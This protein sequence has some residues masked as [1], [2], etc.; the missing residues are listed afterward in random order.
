MDM[1][2]EAPDAAFD[3]AS[4]EADQLAA[5]RADVLA[6]LARPQ[7]AVP[8]RWLY[9][10][11]GSEL[12]EEITRQPEYYL[13][14]TE[15]AILDENAAE[16]AA[17][18]GGDAV[19]LEY[20]AGAGVKTEILLKALA[21]PATYVPIDISGE[22]VA[23]SADRIDRRFP[24]IDV[25]AVVADF[26]ADFDIAAIDG[27]EGP[28]CAFFPGSTLGNLTGNEA[29]ALLS[30]MHRQVGAGGKAILGIDLKKDIDTLLAAYDDAAG[31]TAAFELNLLTRI[32]RE[33]AGDFDLDR[34]NYEARWNDEESAIDMVL[35]SS[36]AQR[37]T[38]DGTPFD[39]AECETI[40]TESSRKYDRAALE[41]LAASTGW[42]LETVWTDPD[43][44]F[45][46]AALRAALTAG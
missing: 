39:F 45:A 46:V 23:H 25:F 4:V 7:K 26:T 42:T 41:T 11:R 33:L 43:G 15:T 44:L 22:F 9:D 37:V 19:I 13:T 35:I 38:I 40:H 18:C 34:F 16:I 24:K 21:L 32:N 8:S 36:A 14:R 27:I 6:G 5:F 17:F 30:R 28:R 1:R 10:E 3:V 2:D 31:V 29:R 12:F 20:G